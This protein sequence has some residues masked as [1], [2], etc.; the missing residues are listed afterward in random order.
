LHS[1]FDIALYP[2]HPLDAAWRLPG[3]T[4]IDNLRGITVNIA[5]RVYLYK[6]ALYL[7]RPIEELR[8]LAHRVTH[9]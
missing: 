5:G 2:Q 4:A 7:Q 3:C 6:V 9:P 8:A 1:A